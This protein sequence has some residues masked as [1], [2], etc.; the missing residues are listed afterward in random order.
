MESKRCTSC[1]CLRLINDF[2]FFS[3][4]RQKATCQSCRTR[5][6]GR[7]KKDVLRAQQKKEKAEIRARKDCDQHKKCIEYQREIYQDSYG[8]LRN[9]NPVVVEEN[10]RQAWEER[11]KEPGC[12][13]PPW[14]DSI[15]EGSA[16]QST[17]WEG[18]VG[19]EEGS[20]GLSTGQEG[21]LGQEERSIGQEQE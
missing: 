21:S 3:Y 14:E 7:A 17:V 18:S 16:G 5:N 4:G 13:L 1:W 9:L 15:E 11:R 20:A 10:A 6:T 19:Q 12:T 8:Q 2:T